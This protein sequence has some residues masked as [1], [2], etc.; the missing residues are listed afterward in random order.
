MTLDRETRT[1]MIA[2]IVRSFK[3]GG[4]KPSRKAVTRLENV[5]NNAS[6]SHIKHLYDFNKI[7]EKSADND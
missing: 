4:S 1:T 2:Y 6:D 7:K 5:L 3:E